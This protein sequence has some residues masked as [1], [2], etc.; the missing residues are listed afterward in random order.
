M[1][2]RFLDL[3]FNII[4]TWKSAALFPLGST[5][6]QHYYF[7]MDMNIMRHHLSRLTILLIATLAC[8]YLH[9]ESKCS[10]YNTQRYVISYLVSYLQHI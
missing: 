2:H 8:L 5:S 6:S 4:S 10:H 1:L 7:L 9:L 3:S